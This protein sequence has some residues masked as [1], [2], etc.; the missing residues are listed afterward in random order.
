MKNIPKNIEAEQALLGLLISKNDTIYDAIDEIE[1][2]EFFKESHYKIYR[3]IIK[4]FETGKDHDIITLVDFLRDN[5]ELKKIGGA[6]YL[7]QLAAGIKGTNAK[8]YA[9]IIREKALLRE[10]LNTCTLIQ[11]WIE[12]NETNIEETIEAAE[13]AIFNIAEKK[14]DRER[15]RD[16]EEILR[17]TVEKIDLVRA[18]TGDYTGVQSGFTDLDRLTAGFQDQDLIILAARPGMGKTAFA[19]NI[20]RNVSEHTPVLFFSLEMGAEQLGTRL[21]SGETGIDSHKMRAGYLSKDEMAEIKMA[22]EKLGKL[23]LMIDDRP[24]ISALD[25]RAKVRRMKAENEIGLVIIDYLQIMKPDEKIPREQQISQLSRQI[26]AIAKEI[27]I[28]IILLSQLN[29]ELERRTDKRP[30]LSDLRESGAIEQDAD[31]VM[32]IYREDVYHDDTP[33]KGIAEIIIEKHRN[34]PTGTVRLFFHEK[35]TSFKNLVLGHDF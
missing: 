28:P 31:I 13:Q 20:A 22:K 16:I 12:D 11:S 3:A 14:I 8:M 2:W 19:L 21:L 23:N 27:D 24:Y 1:G 9:R 6:G 30:Q 18:N 7:A 35:T 15:I 34:G 32:F 25:I 4:L 33:E 5:G 10:L 29:R 26:K 17:S